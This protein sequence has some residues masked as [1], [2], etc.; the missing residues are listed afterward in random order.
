MIDERSLD[1]FGSARF[2][3]DR[4]LRYRLRRQIGANTTP[5][6]A[7]VV[8]VMLNPSTADAFKPD[9]TVSK[10]CEFARRWGASV[11][12]VVN[13]FALVSPYPRD[14]D[15]AHDRGESLGTDVAANMEILEAC[16]GAAR[17]IAAWGNGAR[18]GRDEEVRDLLWRHGIKLERLGLTQDGHPL[19]PLARGKSFIPL[20][21]QPEPHL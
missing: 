12:E 18:F 16:T 14:L 9:R 15:R 6:A 1:G 10:C 13:L 19:H 3:D 17:V 5:W 2:S 21:T 8:F 20:S 4:R 7:R 11:L